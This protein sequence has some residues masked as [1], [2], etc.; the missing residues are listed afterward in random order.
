VGSSCRDREANPKEI[1]IPKRSAGL[2]VYRPVEAGIEVL[3]VHPGGPFWAKKDKGA[4]SIPKGELE[5][6]EQPAEIEEG[7]PFPEEIYSAA[8]REYEEE[9]GLP[10]P[11]GDPMDLGEIR[12]AGGK[13]VR[14]FAL[15][16]GG[17][18]GQ[19]TTDPLATLSIKSNLV[20]LE[21]PRG[22]GRM[23]TF[24]EVDKAQW[25]SPDTAREKLIPSQVVFVDRLLERLGA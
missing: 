14:A 5:P 21:W 3:A 15:R 17:P 20:E 6:S 25:M 24:P 2:L 19:G 16:F 10:A 11:D 1:A 23:L 9:I 8:R 22:T 12:Q 4:W 18:D 13:I 7:G